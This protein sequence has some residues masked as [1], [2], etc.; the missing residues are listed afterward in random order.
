VEAIY[1]GKATKYIQIKELYIANPT[2]YALN[3]ELGRYPRESDKV[4]SEGFSRQ[5]PKG[6]VGAFEKQDANTLSNSVL[7]QM[8][9]F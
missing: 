2:P 5:A 4:T 8:K 7:R 1:S 9:G 3:Y 6:V